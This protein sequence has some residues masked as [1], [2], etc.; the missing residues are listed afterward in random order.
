MGNE[1]HE[2]RQR[3]VTK[4]GVYLQ[5]YAENVGWCDVSES[6]FFFFYSASSCFECQLYILNLLKK[7][8]TGQ[9]AQH[10]THLY[11]CMKLCHYEWTENRV[12]VLRLDKI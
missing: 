10:I 8:N 1:C 3:N 9:I 11:E 2:N 6:F 4:S 7:H 5:L 12:G